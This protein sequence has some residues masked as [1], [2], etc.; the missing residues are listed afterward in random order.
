MYEK[1][2][3]CCAP[4]LQAPSEAER[5]DSR[6]HFL[7]LFLHGTLAQRVV[8]LQLVLVQQLQDSAWGIIVDSVVQVDI[9]YI[10]ITIPAS[11]WFAL[12]EISS[13]LS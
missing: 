2:I 3:I 12:D 10:V 5:F 1:S 13:F 8:C 6:G 9:G 11:V 4:L 7:P